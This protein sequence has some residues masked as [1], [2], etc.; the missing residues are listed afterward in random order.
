MDISDVKFQKLGSNVGTRQWLFRSER[1]TSKRETKKG[2][3]P[4]NR[5]DT[6]FYFVSNFDKRGLLAELNLIEVD[7]RRI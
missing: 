6:K 7:T 5:L 1:E 3:R 4:K 2:L